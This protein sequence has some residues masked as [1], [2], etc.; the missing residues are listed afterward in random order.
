LQKYKLAEQNHIDTNLATDDI[1]INTAL[2]TKQ[3]QV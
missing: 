2:A 3:N 1:C